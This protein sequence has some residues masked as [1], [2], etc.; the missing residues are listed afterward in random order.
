MDDLGR[1]EIELGE[2]SR[3]RELGWVRGYGEICLN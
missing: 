3:K 1:V 2:W